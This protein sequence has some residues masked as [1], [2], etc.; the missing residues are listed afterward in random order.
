[1]YSTDNLDDILKKRNLMRGIC[2][3]A[4]NIIGVFHRRCNSFVLGENNNV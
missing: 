2:G 4:K 3:K 1:M